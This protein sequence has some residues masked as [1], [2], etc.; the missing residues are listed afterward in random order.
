M[1]QVPFLGQILSADGF[2]PDPKNTEPITKIRPPT[3]LTE[4][5]SFLGMVTHY[6][7]YI[8][9]LANVAELLIA[10]KWKDM[11]FVL[12][13]DCQSA[14]EQLK[15]IIRLHLKLAL[16]DPCCDMHIN[17]DAS[18]V[19]LGATLTQIQ[20]GQEVMITRGSHTLSETER[21]PLVVCGQLSSLRGTYW[22]TLLSC[23]LTNMH[24]AKC[25]TVPR[26]LRVS[27]KCPNMCIG[28]NVSLLMIS[29]W[30]SSRVKKTMYLMLCRTYP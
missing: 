16:F 14:F 23:T 9:D 15:I 17:V 3:N 8:A 13:N 4:L 10:L 20:G 2:H 26:K 18:N 25:W 29:C 12:S 11:P 27:T 6:G 1:Q 19:G 21:W 22:A 5:H 30:H 28:L 24:F 7:N